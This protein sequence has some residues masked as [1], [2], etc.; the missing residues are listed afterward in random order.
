METT[1]IKAKE[2]VMFSAQSSKQRAFEAILENVVL[3]KKM[4]RRRYIPVSMMAPILPLTVLSKDVDP[5]GTVA[6]K[7][8]EEVDVPRVQNGEIE[9]AKLVETGDPVP[10]YVAIVNC[11]YLQCKP[12][13]K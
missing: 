5:S 3:L 9:V 12:H 4:A 8:R 7:L 13:C 6:T 2:I 10:L 11:F 1:F